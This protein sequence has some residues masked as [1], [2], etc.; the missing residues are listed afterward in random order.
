LRR[1][2]AVSDDSPSL[3]TEFLLNRNE[4]EVSKVVEILPMD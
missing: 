1:I 2:D 3:D 4:K